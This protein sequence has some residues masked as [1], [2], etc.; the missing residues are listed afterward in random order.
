MLILVG[1][2]G[3]TNTRLR[4]V[5]VRESE[6]V[7]IAQ[8]DYPSQKFATFIDVLNEFKSEYEVPA[9]IDAVC[10]A[11]AGPVKSS[12]V[13]VTNL[14][15]L[16]SEAEL[17]R[18]FNTSNVYLINDFIAIS[19]GIC[20]LQASD[21]LT[22]QETKN[23][24]ES[25]SETD[26]AVIGAGTGLGASHLIWRGD[27]YQA[28]PAE[29]GHA[30]FSPETR[31]QTELLS[32][33]QTSQSHISLEDLLSGRGLY[34]IY[35][36]FRDT[37]GINESSEVRKAMEDDDPAK[38]I[39]DYAL[40]ETD[41]LSRNALDLFVDIYGASAGNITLH[42]YPVDT[43]YIAGGIAEKIKDK[44][45]SKRFLDAF[46]NKGLMS[47]NMKQIT[48]KI[49]LNDRV[50]LLGALSLAYRRLTAGFSENS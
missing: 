50:G 42:Y 21:F 43:I 10:M 7:I 24:I 47:E 33:L 45:N 49:V 8:G 26:A 19:Y 6:Q 40:L 41:E 1:D 32:W 5:E 25:L 48:I 44:L 46:T 30:G 15:W 38:V 27:Y 29:A 14:P 18:Y 3:G 4:L 12:V 17:S 39:S 34:K 11:I 37:S 31:Q 22:I 36:F 28:L 35:Q 13:S 20:D 2:I 16:I 9:N 23:Q